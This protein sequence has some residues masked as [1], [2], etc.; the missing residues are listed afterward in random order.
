MEKSVK[1]KKEKKRRFSNIPGVFSVS[2]T[3]AGI[4]RIIFL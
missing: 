3:H 4:A 1:K 2:G